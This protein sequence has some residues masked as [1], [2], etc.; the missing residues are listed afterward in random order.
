MGFVWGQN[1]SDV[2]HTA[3]GT[4]DNF[5]YD[6]RLTARGHYQQAHYYT[7]MHAGIAVAFSSS[8]IV[9]AVFLFHD[10]APVAI[11]PFLP[12]ATSPII[13]RTLLVVTGL[14]AWAKLLS[15]QLALPD[16]A[17]KHRNAGAAYNGLARQANTLLHTLALPD[18]AASW[19]ALNARRNEV[20]VNFCETILDSV[21]KATKSSESFRAE[22]AAHREEHNLPR[23]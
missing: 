12:A 17:A 8:A 3:F 15:V 2:M 21:H 13:V 19:H 11:K 16:L 7:I 22:V 6:C 20:E 4:I 1:F 14:S 9:S 5:W 18:A 23:A 10:R